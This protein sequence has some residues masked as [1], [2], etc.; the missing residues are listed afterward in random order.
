MD[1]LDPTVTRSVELPAAPDR[2]WR[3]LED[4]DE[5]SAWLGG[6]SR[7]D[8]RPGGSGHAVDEDGI[9]RCVA[10]HS[11]D[12][13]RRLTWRWWPEDGGDGAT[14]EFELEPVGPGTRLTVTERPATDAST[15]SASV[16]APVVAGRLLDLELLLLALVAV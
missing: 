3:A 7:I 9:V 13:G 5:R 2:V 14:V 11:V 1:D 4:D 15:I 8:V 10:V 12:P 16:V 6:R